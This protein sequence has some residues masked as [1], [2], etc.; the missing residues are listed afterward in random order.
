MPAGDEDGL[1]RHVFVHVVPAVFPHDHGED[2]EAGVVLGG[3]G[4]DEAALKPAFEEIE[5]RRRHVGGRNE[6]GVVGVDDG[7]DADPSEGAVLVLVGRVDR[8]GAFRLEGEQRAR[9]LPLAEILDG[10]KDREVGLH[11]CARELPLDP[12]IEVG[13]QAAG[14]GDR[15]AGKALLEILDPAV[16]GAGRAG[17]V[18][19]DGL[20]QLRLFVKR[21]HA[22]GARLQR[23]TRQRCGEKSRDARK[24]RACAHGVSRSKLHL[25]ARAKTKRRPCNV[26]GP[27]PISSARYA[28][29]RI[30]S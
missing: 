10:L 29:T 13:A 20:F 21:L 19:D 27:A 15:D 17:A 25:R 30:L 22:L 18:E 3:I 2:R 1:L 7:V 16:V 14:E 28:K 24:V 11:R 9:L 4:G 5:G 26:T 23:A 6:V 12:L 8:L